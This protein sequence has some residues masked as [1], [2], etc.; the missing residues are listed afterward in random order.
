VITI[1]DTGLDTKRWVE[2]VCEFPLGAGVVQLLVPCIAAGVII[3]HHS[4]ADR[5]KVMC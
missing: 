5:V 2:S 4:V 1:P 3:C